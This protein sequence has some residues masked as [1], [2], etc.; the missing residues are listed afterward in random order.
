M[1]TKV[2]LSK[3][4]KDF[5]GILQRRLGLIAATMRARR[6]EIEAIFNDF[7]EYQ[8]KERNVPPN[9]KFDID[10]MAFIPPIEEVEEDGS[11][12]DDGMDNRSCQTHG[13]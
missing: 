3:E 4:E 11:K 1:V 6:D 2:V 8:R 12:N 9:W 5:L 7:V 10:E 13:E